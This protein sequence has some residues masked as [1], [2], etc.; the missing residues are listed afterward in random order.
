MKVQRLCSPNPIPSYRMLTGKP[1]ISDNIRT[2]KR[3]TRLATA[4][5]VTASTQARSS[6]RD[7]VELLQ[8]LCTFDS[9]SDF[10]NWNRSAVVRLVLRIHTLTSDETEILSPVDQSRTTEGRARFSTNLVEMELNESKVDEFDVQSAIN[11]ALYAIGDASRFW[12]Q[13]RS[14]KNR[15]SNKPSS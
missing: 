9:P 13:G 2:T 14:N 10:G 6:L 1:T 3:V 15:G 8:S 12:L 5:T 7:P 11:F 4:T